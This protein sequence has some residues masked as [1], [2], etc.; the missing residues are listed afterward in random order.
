MKHHAVG[1][2]LVLLIAGTTAQ[3]PSQPIVTL[4]HA[5]PGYRLAA[6]C[7]RWNPVAWVN[8]LVTNAGGVPTAPLTLGATDTTGRLSGT[9][10]VGP[11]AAGAVTRVD[12]PL[13]QSARADMSGVHPIIVVV[14]ENNAA[15]IDTAIPI[16]TT[17]CSP[18]LSSTTVL[19]SRTALATLPPGVEPVKA[20]MTSRVARAIVSLSSLSPE[21]TQVRLGASRAAL[22]ALKPASSVTVSDQSNGMSK[23]KFVRGSLSASADSASLSRVGALSHAD[24]EYAG[25]L[26]ITSPNRGVD[27]SKPILSSGLYWIIAR[28]AD[29]AIPS[30][31]DNTYSVTVP[32]CNLSY[33]VTGGGLWNPRQPGGAEP[34]PRNYVAAFPYAAYVLGFVPSGWGVFPT[35]VNPHRM[36]IRYPVGAHLLT[37]S[38]LVQSND[39]VQQSFVA[40][41]DENGALAKDGGLGMT[42]A[43]VE[44]RVPGLRR[45]NTG[46]LP[47]AGE[48]VIGKGIALGPG[49][50][51]T[52][53]I[54]A[55]HS[56]ADIGGDASPDNPYRGASVTIQPNSG[57]LQTVV[58]WHVEPQ[59]SLQYAI[60]WTFTGRPGQRPVLTMPLG[61]VCDS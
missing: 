2:V 25:L 15:R 6:S 26:D 56:M 47:I 8:V 22:A 23:A 58:A 30:T 35:G 50:T 12:V 39:S 55:A 10:A 49:V 31:L 28:S 40:V 17:L 38:F 27:T 46:A 16:P 19:K 9:G 18:G 54:V 60:Q 11:L 33:T 59:E 41:I 48:D 21:Q 32:D 51:A 20:P 42:A 36:M 44:Y 53:K 43:N 14:R 24:L 61:K 1:S 34:V 13:T 45:V 57:R 37:A 52:A 29:P 4:A 5:S 3:T 7:D